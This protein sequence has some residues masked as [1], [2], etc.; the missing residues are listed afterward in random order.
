MDME[1]SVGAMTATVSV[2]L[3]MFKM[4]V[5]VAAPSAFPVA[6]PLLLTATIP[7]GLALQVTEADISCVLASLEGP[8]A[9]NW[10][11]CIGAKVLLCGYSAIDTS[12]GSATASAPLP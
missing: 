11:E 8:T 9:F 2:A 4:A 3:T 6:I 10:A 1:L 7:A 5:I 12:G